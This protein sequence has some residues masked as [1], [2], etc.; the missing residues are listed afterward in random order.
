LSFGSPTASTCWA[1]GGMATFTAL[2]EGV[3]ATASPEDCVSAGLK[4][5][6]P[7]P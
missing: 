6:V 4:L 2:G 3:A 1:G 7:E 5:S